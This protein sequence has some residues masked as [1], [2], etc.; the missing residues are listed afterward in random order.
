MAVCSATSTIFVL[1]DAMD[2]VLMGSAL[3]AMEKLASIFSR[4]EDLS[5]RAPQG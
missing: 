2:V 4:T 1:E 3:G 5:T